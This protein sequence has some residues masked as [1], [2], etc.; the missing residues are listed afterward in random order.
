[1]TNTFN[2]DTGEAI[3]EFCAD[4]RMVGVFL[5]DEVLR[6]NPDFN[7]HEKKLWTTTLIKDFKGTVQFVVLRTEGVHEEDTEFWKRGETWVDYSVEVIGHGINKV[8]GDPINFVGK[9]TGF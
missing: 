7:L 9:Q 2:L 5:L 4:T 8:T 3:G 6:Y 1:M